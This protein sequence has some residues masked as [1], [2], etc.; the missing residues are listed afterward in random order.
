MNEEEE[1]KEPVVG[2]DTGYEHTSGDRSD[3]GYCDDSLDSTKPN[4]DHK[5]YWIPLW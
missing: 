4:D 1:D 3:D 5:E 2:S